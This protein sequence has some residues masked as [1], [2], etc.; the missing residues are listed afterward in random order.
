VSCSRT[1]RASITRAEL[2]ARTL[3]LLH[4]GNR[5]NPDV[6]LVEDGT[7]RMVVKDF[8]PR[9][10][11]VRATLGRLV[12]AR[13]AGA[14]RWLVG[15]PNV[16][17]FLG[18]IDPL[19]I[20]V[21]YRPGRRMSRHLAEDA[22][23]GFVAA[24]REAVAELH[25]RGLVHLDLGHRSNVLVDE[26]GEP[27]LIDFASAIWFRPGSLGARV[28]LPRL[29]AHDRRAVAKWIAKLDRQRSLRSAGGAASEGGRKQSRPT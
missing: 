21:E 13:E 18:W 28:L 16:P 19:A 4:R 20:A 15:H 22:S 17:R 3:E 10:A 5:H 7:R 27:I 2:V 14:Y 23:P 24:L 6:L 1:P 12:T 8:A 11:L 26:R 9:G 29:A 25:R